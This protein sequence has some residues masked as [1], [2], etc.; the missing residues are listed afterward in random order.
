MP[1]GQPKGMA[2]AQPQLLPKVPGL[3]SLWIFQE[4]L[5][6]Q[7]SKQNLPPLFKLAINFLK[8]FSMAAGVMRQACLL[9]PSTGDREGVGWEGKHSDQAPGSL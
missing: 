2:I 4:K 5:E 7:V 6:S 8:I 9:E 1:S 3:L